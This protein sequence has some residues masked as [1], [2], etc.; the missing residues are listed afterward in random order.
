M[1]GYSYIL[2]IYIRK[3]SFGVWVKREEIDIVGR[4]KG[5]IFYYIFLPIVWPR[6][7]YHF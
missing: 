7:D 1:H 6:S 5:M 3:L 4:K 2:E